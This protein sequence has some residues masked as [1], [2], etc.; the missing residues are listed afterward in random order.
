MKLIYFAT[1]CVSF[2]ALSCFCFDL[3]TFNLGSD[4]E[5]EQDSVSLLKT[6]VLR[7]E[8]TKKKTTYTF[9]VSKNVE[10]YVR[11]QLPDNAAELYPSDE[12]H[13][14]IFQVNAGSLDAE[15]S[16]PVEISVRQF[17]RVINFQ[18]PAVVREEDRLIYKSTYKSVDFCPVSEL[19]GNTTVLMTLSSSSSTPVSVN[20]RVFIKGKSAEWKR[21]RSE[22]AGF[23]TNTTITPA[24]TRIRYFS[25]DLMREMSGNY[26]YLNIK[27]TMREESDCLCSLVSIQ[28]PTCPFHD[29]AGA[30]MRYGRWATMLN[31]S[32]IIV[33]SRD[34]KDGFIIVLVASASDDLC[35]IAL[36][37]NKCSAYNANVTN[38]RKRVLVEVEGNA[39]E[40][41]YAAATLTIISSYIGI[42]VLTV[43]ISL[44]EFSY[45]TEDFEAL[46]IKLKETYEMYKV[47]GM[48]KFN[49]ISTNITRR[50]SQETVQEGFHVIDGL[51]KTVGTELAA[52]SPSR[53]LPTFENEI[54]PSEDVHNRVSTFIDD[55]TNKKSPSGLNPPADLDV[56]G[57]NEQNGTKGVVEVEE[58]AAKVDT[59]KVTLAVE[60]ADLEED[61]YEARHRVSYSRIASAAEMKEL[62]DEVDIDERLNVRLKTDLRVSELSMKLDDPT[63]KK[64]VYQ[65]SELF[66]GILLL[67]SMFYSLPVLQ[68]VFAFSHSQRVTGNQDI[69]FYND[70]CRRPL[71]LIRD[72]NHVFSNVGYMVFGAL[73]MFLVLLKKWKYNSFLKNNKDIK[74][75]DFGVPQQYGLFFSMGLALLMEGI[76]SGSYHIC[77]TNITF[78]FDTTFMYLMCILMFLK[79][80]QVRHADVSANAVGVFFGLGVSLFLETISI[81][82]HGTIFWTFFSLIYLIVIVVSVV[83]GYNLGV[84]RYDYKILYNVAKILYYE[85]RRMLN[86]KPGDA[87]MPRVRSRLMFLIVS[88]TVNVILCLY[89]GI[90]GTPGASNYL[91]A[92]YILNLAMYFAY[93]CI[94]KVLNGESIGWASSL[95]S[96][97]SLVCVIPALYFFTQKEKNSEV[98]PAESRMLNMECIFLNFFDGHDVWHFLGG[99]GLFFS[100]LAIFTID[101]DLKYRR[102]DT[103]PVF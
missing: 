44:V 25:D 38:L 55:E 3:P 43:I 72:F 40:A 6:K 73:F 33:D 67:I 83:H 60:E 79:L 14:H 31:F 100:F 87:Y 103:I 37:E 66:L 71:H 30:A 62:V 15:V 32:T 61:T 12:D 2:F 102:R 86:R 8:I 81:F 99:A 92:I 89:F 21:T 76:M 53:E 63:R 96:A 24:I 13:Q 36:E 18:L 97:L 1:L 98:S 45:N 51:R 75:N 34:Y 9:R 54:E 95:Y 26:T 65:K 50:V 42:L 59:K 58:E 39:S 23:S 16:H 11:F 47:V 56:E 70:L 77:P 27:V 78:Q 4:E 28:S 41:T 5:A 17:R 80:Y 69:C 90:S 74:E 88:G 68:M 29:T 19:S 85:V 22:I 82:Y 7:K 52:G 93:Y 20:V 48:E 46:N 35:N 10:Y 94:M 57:S 101:E 91:L 64:S 84:V 49:A